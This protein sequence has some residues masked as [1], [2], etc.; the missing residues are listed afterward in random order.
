MNEI[1]CYRCEDV[2]E[3]WCETRRYGFWDRESQ[4]Y[5][6]QPIETRL[7]RDCWDDKEGRAPGAHYHPESAQELWDVLAA[8]DGRL[9]GV[10][11]WW[12]GRPAIRVVDGN[13]EAAVTK[14]HHAGQTDDGTPII[15]FRSEL[16]DGFDRDEFDDVAEVPDERGLVRLLSPERTSFDG[17]DS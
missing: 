8:A 11:C 7:C 1:A 16:I 10:L 3:E 15:E 4:N 14:P 2:I 6:R 12:S 17:V 5:E 9:A 13:A